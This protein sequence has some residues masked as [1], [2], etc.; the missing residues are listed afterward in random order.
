[1]TRI[2]LLI[3]GAALLT[4]D[5]PSGPKRGDAMRDVGLISDGA[6]AINEGRIVAL[7]R[8]SDLLA[9]YDATQSIDASG[10]IVCP[11]F[12]DCHTHL[13]YGGDRSDEFE[14]RIAG[15]SYMEIMAA[16]GGILNTMQGT[17]AASEAELEA[18]AS[19]LLD[20][21]LYLGTTT[22]EIKTGYGLDTDTEVKMLRVIEILD[23]SHPVELIPTFLGAH[24][25]PPEYRD[26]SDAFVDL[27]ID[28]MLPAAESWYAQSHFKQQGVPF[29]VDVFCERNAFDV[30]QS[31]RILEAAKS[32]GLLLK[33]HVDE[34]TALGGLSLAL[35]LGVTSVDHLDV[36][37][38]DEIAALADS[39]SVAVLLPAVNFN[40]GSTHFADARA[41]LDSGAAVALSTDFNP[42]SA[43]CVSLPLVMGMATRYQ[44][45]LPSE[46]LN[47]VTINAAHALGIA[48]RVGSLA[49][50]KQA[51]VLILD[52]PDYRHLA[53][54]LG[55]NPVETV[56]KRG[57]VLQ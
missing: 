20:T 42:G 52:V 33:A 12:V 28:E 14:M 45:M 1:M 17:R 46:A 13:I 29:F 27:V 56:I 24:A 53:Y 49:V 54:V 44:K 9:D 48:N 47:A 51:D 25:I 34:F 8:S 31:R 55:G 38:P 10:K 39:S 22:V 15:A 4:C 37:T 21:M 50:G 32:R 11:G 5:H 3:H 43:P 6:L 19:N 23:Q 36:S 2:D 7:G 26:Q 40:L 35:S 41:I 18:R 57:Q 16:G 30:A